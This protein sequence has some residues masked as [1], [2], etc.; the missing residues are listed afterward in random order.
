VFYLWRI[1][2]QSAP[3]CANPLAAPPLKQRPNRNGLT[4]G[5]AAD[6]T[7]EK[8]INKRKINNLYMITQNILQKKNSILKK[9]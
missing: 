5:V 6:L 9:F 8:T 2:K 7:P 1:A 3:I 4:S